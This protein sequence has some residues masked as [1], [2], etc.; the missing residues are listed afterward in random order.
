MLELFLL[1]K[2]INSSHLF[3]SGHHACLWHHKWEVFWKHQE[4]DKEHR[5]GLYCN[6]TDENFFF[7]SEVYEMANV[8]VPTWWHF[9]FPVFSACI[10]WCWKN[11]AWQ[12]VWHQWQ[13]AGFQRQRGEG[14][15][16]KIELEVEEFLDYAQSVVQHINVILKDILIV[17]MQSLKYWNVCLLLCTKL[18]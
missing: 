7:L 18:L 15:T 8:I 9:S 5:R 1:L 17:L 13:T 16:L 12:Q 2:C 6:T 3:F 11:G 10:S 4:L 14:E